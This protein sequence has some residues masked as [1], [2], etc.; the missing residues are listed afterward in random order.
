[1]AAVYVAEFVSIAGTGNF[2]IAAAQVAPVN[3]QT[4]AIGGSSATIATAFNPKSRF[5]RVHTDAICS[6]AFGTAPVATITNMR[7]SANQTE[8]FGL[9][10]TA[11]FKMAV[12]SNT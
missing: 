1:M 4:I 10:P 7:M 2:A 11:N 9:P 3:E 8:Y 6:I 5:I 12:I